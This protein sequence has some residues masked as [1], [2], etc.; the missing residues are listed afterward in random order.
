MG[1]AS[2]AL[3]QSKERTRA[4]THFDWHSGAVEAEWEEASLSF[5]GLVTNCKLQHKTHFTHRQHTAINTV[6]Y[7]HQ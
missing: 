6:Q 7:P 3:V 5:Q 1:F 4:S 2:L